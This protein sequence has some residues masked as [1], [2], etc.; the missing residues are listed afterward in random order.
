MC[1]SSMKT[2]G[3]QQDCLAGVTM[4]LALENGVLVSWTR[5]IEALA[6]RRGGFN[7]ATA[8][9]DLREDLDVDRP[10]VKYRP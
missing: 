3:K 1:R 5:R 7:C 6:G 4:G 10:H 8:T 9:L 2:L